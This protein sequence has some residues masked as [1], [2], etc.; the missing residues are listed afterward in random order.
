MREWSCY[1][2]WMLTDECICVRIEWICNLRQLDLL[3]TPEPQSRWY[4]L[5]LHKTTMHQHHRQLLR[6]EK[7]SALGCHFQYNLGKFENSWIVA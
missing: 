5:R 3:D 7:F 6:F 1:Y 4:T 2:G